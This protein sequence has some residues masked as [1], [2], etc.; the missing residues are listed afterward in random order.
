[1]RLGV[2]TAV[3]LF[4]SCSTESQICGRME[5]LC[6]TARE[7][8]REMIGQTRSAFGDQGVEDLK[9]CFARSS[10]CGE[11]TGCTTAKGLKAVGAAI[12]G[13]FKGLV[14]GVDEPKK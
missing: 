8:C 7:S 1:M 14:N 2:L 4:T 5:T 13:F 3:L 10:T 11:A 12:E 6:G 9:V